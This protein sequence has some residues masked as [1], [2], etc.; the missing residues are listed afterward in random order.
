MSTPIKQLVGLGQSIWYD[1][2]ER[3]LLMNGELVAMVERGDIQGLTSN[4][5]IF[6]NAI[7]NSNDYDADLLPLAQAG[8]TTLEIFEA[9]AVEDIRAA[10]DLLGPLYD[11]TN[12]GDGYVSL[13]VNPTLA[14]DTDATLSE[15]KRLWAWVDRP[16][17][18]IKI[19]AT[20]AGLPAIR[21]AIA[22]GLNVNVTLIFSIERY[23]AVMDAYL[24]G[25]V[26]RAVQGLP[27]NRIAS[28]ASFF[29][30]RIDV[31]IDKRLQALDSERASA[32]LGQAAIANA[33]LA[34][35]AFKA[36]FGN[37]R[38]TRLKEHGAWV[39]RPLWAS[40]GTKNPA[41]PDTLYVDELIGPQTVN[42]M[43]PATLDAFRD[44]GCAELTI[45]SDLDGADHVF[46]EL[47]ALG[48]SM[49]EVTQALEEEGVKAF[50]DS[51]ESLMNTIASRQS[52]STEP[53]G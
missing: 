37:D 20:A 41:Y 24:A 2:I 46:A 18:M 22:A 5:T 25:L 31:K 14:Y 7:A 38:F 6:N 33:R 1:N 32:L 48:I 12:G 26:D 23:E 3:R 11:D 45:E 42:T 34:Y 44:H 52:V 53:A 40:T 28:V 17:L 29:V 10:A 8:K 50:A 19:P 36:V 27:V 51:F 9:L 4:P 43:P 35:Q 49:A 13:E 39:Q 30:S 15:A 21:Q 47:E 16:N